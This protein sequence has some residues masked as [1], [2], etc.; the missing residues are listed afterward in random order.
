MHVIDEPTRRFG[1]LLHYAGLLA[2]VICVTA[3]YSFVHAPVVRSIAA[4]SARIDELMQSVHNAPVIREQH[5]HVSEKLNEV[6]TRIA[7]VQGRVPNNADDGVFLKQVT[8][9]A[10]AE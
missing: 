3:G 1:R 9:L 4:T 2:T 8:K 5:H 10:E 7:N 6:T